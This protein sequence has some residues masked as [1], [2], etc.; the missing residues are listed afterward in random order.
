[1]SARRAA[2]RREQRKRE[3]AQRNHSLNREL[4]RAREQGKIDG[5]VL[6]VFVSLIILHDDFGW[7]NE[8]GIKLIEKGNAES[9]R[10]DNDGVRFVASHWIDKIFD[11]WHEANLPKITTNKVADEVYYTERADFYVNGLAVIAM[12]LT[13]E[14]GFGSRRDGT[15]RI[16]RFLVKATQEYTNIIAGKSVEEYQEEVFEKMKINFK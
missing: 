11:Y 15:G 7:G 14:F 10:F 4:V 8:R 12:V 13:S 1:M 9:C 2:I 5:R 3:K 16:D 6:S